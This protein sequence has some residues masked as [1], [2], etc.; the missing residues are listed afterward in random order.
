MLTELDHS[1][2]LAHRAFHGHSTTSEVS[3]NNVGLQ[4]IKIGLTII[5]LTSLGTFRSIVLESGD[6]SATIGHSKSQNAEAEIPTNWPNCSQCWKWRRS[7]QLHQRKPPMSLPSILALSVCT[8]PRYASLTVYAQRL[9]PSIP[10]TQQ[11]H[12]ACVLQ[13]PNRAKLCSTCRKQRPPEEFFDGET[14]LP[15]IYLA[16][17]VADPFKPSPT[18]QSHGPPRRS[19]E[20]LHDL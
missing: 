15:L 5:N 10:D 18:V 4:T 8:G 14:C 9:V 17:L 1:E 6:I 7:S 2:H 20:L 16:L 19:L 12:N 3:K 11:N 13:A